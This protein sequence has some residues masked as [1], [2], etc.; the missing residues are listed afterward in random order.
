MK[1]VINLPH[2][3]AWPNTEESPESRETFP[4]FLLNPM[5]LINKYLVINQPMKF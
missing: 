1:C 2:F 4:L 3:S 5:M